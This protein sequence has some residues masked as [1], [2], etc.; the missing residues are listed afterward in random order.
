MI[1]RLV[2]SAVSLV[3]FAGATAHADVVNSFNFTSVIDGG[4]SA[5]GV[6]NINST[7]GN[8]LSSDFSLYDSS[9]TVIRTFLNDPV[10]DTFDGF[11]LVQFG[12]TNGDYIFEL[13]LPVSNLVGY[14]GGAIC[15]DS[16]PCDGYA[17]GFYDLATSEG[18]DSQSGTLT[19][20]TPEPSSLVLLGTGMLGLVGVARRRMTS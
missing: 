13:L 18:Y 16:A 1:K 2:L 10:E 6:I 20:V 11:Y 19:S 3:A 5:R 14:T 4:Y 8:T 12:R 9:D 15:S 17:S 7:T